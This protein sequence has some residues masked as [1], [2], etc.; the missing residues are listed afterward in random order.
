MDV[1]GLS[2]KLMAAPCFSIT[3]PRLQKGKIVAYLQ[4]L[5]SHPL[6]LGSCIMGSNFE[7]NVLVYPNCAVHIINIVLFLCTDWQTWQSAF[8]TYLEWMHVVLG[9]AHDPETLHVVSC[10]AFE[11]IQ[12]CASWPIPSLLLSLPCPRPRGI[13]AASTPLPLTCSHFALSWCC[14][15]SSPFGEAAVS[16]LSPLL[17]PHLFLSLFASWGL[18]HSAVHAWPDIRVGWS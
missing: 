13:P 17:F 1:G 4:G 10:Y 12:T 6:I 3:I 2:G 5:N 18:Q 16:A 7:N 15:G 11:D 9:F 8:C 14:P